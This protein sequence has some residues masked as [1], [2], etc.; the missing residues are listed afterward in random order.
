MSSQV[1][2][3]KVRKN[4]G[5]LVDFD[6]NKL[7][8]ALARSGANNHEIE[9]V[10][11]QI[12]S[13]I[14]DGIT[15]HKIYQIAY[16]ILKKI[17]YRTAGHYR[18]KKAMLELGPTGYPFEQFIARLLEF[19]GYEVMTDQIVK[20]RCV[21]HEVDVIARK[22]NRQIMVECKYHS[23]KSTKSDV[24]VPLYINSRFLDVSEAWKKLPGNQGKTFQGMLVTNSRFTE[25]ALQYGKCAGLIM[26]SWDYPSGSSLKDWID[27][28]G[29]HPLTSL[30][31][32]R[33]NEKQAFL[34]KGIVLC[35]DIIENP[36]I[37]EEI[38]QSSQRRN[39]LKKE[40]KSV[41]D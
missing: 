4:T 31:C 37:T 38:V 26:V 10:I 7:R 16:G 21:N 20:G 29:Y 19:Q 6:I 39:S 25:D 3:I 18:L 12:Q 28:S 40:V 34:E 5:E 22:E 17:S 32:L 8:N 36:L 33:K 41:L 14:Y 23:D 27:R 24:K 35:R 15:T 1:K 13:S 2:T 30:Q 9:K 11:T